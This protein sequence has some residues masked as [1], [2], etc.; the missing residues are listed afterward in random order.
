TPLGFDVG[1]YRALCRQWGL[2][3]DRYRATKAAVGFGDGGR[4]RQR[5]Y[6]DA[7]RDLVAPAMGTPAVIRVPVLDRDGA[8]AYQR[9][10]DHLHRAL[11]AHSVRAVRQTDYGPFS[12]G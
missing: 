10:R 7:L 11:V 12:S 5:A 9:V 3:A 1:E 6:H 4:Q 2:R 8:A